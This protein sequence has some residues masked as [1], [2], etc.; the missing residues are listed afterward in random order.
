MI[1]NKIPNSI[2]KSISSAPIPASSSQP[3]NEGKLPKYN[4]LSQA[5]EVK[6]LPE[7]SELGICRGSVEA[8]VQ[9]AAP[10][11]LPALCQQQMHVLRLLGHLHRERLENT[12]WKKEL[13]PA[14]VSTSFLRSREF[15]ACP[16]GLLPAVLGQEMLQ[17]TAE[18][19]NPEGWGFPSLFR[20]TGHR[21]SCI[22]TGM[23]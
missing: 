5:S 23:W 19:G 14:F 10:T 11:P 1:R 13:P 2:L 3:N 17:R 16:P 6:T 8:G 18:R 7:H 22:P 4:I 20:G 15:L 21:P 12:S 9:A